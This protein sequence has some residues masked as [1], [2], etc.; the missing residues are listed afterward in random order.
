V[1]GEIAFD[2]LVKP[3]RQQAKDLW[4]STKEPSSRKV[5]ALAKKR[6]WEVSAKTLAR[7]HN[8][9][10]VEPVH[11]P[12]S[13][14]QKKLT[15]ATRELRKAANDLTSIDALKANPAVQ[16]AL[17][18]VKN[19]EYKP[20]H[21]SDLLKLDKAQLKEAA[22][23]ILMATTIVIA[24]AVCEKASVVSLTPKEVGAFVESS[25]NAMKAIA[26]GDE[27]PPNAGQPGDNATVIEEVAAPPNPIADNIRKF[28]AKMGAA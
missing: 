3:T 10:W 13:M 21:L 11:V 16:E 4:Y 19:A 26:S 23:K 22:E 5:A 6:G 2:K 8:Q 28:K 15:R 12:T 20:R 18:A 1:S 24:E 17:V 9:G 14:A 27:V 25:N 7:W